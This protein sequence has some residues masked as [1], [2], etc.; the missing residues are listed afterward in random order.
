MEIIVDNLTKK[1]K[2]VTVLDNINM[3]FESGKIYGLIGPNGV[4]K[5]SII[6]CLVGVYKITKGNIL[7]N[8]LDIYNNP[9]IKKKI[10][11]VSDENNYF[12]SFKVKD[13]IK[14][15]ENCY[16]GFDYKKFY[17]LNKIFKVPENKNLFQ[18]SKGNKMRVFILI[19]L[20]IKNI[21][22][23]ILDE[24]TS[25]LDPILKN[26]LLKIFLKEVSSRNISIII[27]SHYLSELENICDKVI[28]VKNGTI[29]Y[30][31]SL[32][33]MREKIKKVQVAFDEPVYEED[34]KVNGVYSIKKV[35]RVF[36]IITENYGQD[37]L[38]TLNKYNPLFI[39]EIDL[40]LEDVLISKV[41]K[42]DDY[43]EIL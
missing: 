43:E 41:D 36:N 2:K 23:I 38:D 3:K 40:S 4:G 8:G 32:D 13:I 34:L 29:D 28:I 6:K 16:D 24:P 15:Y 21:E 35:G 9:A 14:F 11:Y 37:F 5:T 20:C 10:A 7:Y 25:G 30:I 18:L 12:L 17:K 19:A 22:Y 31:N 39:E 1:F 26:K 42:E 33:N 27:S